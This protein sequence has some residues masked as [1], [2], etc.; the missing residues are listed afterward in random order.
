ML[1][2][3]SQRQIGMALGKLVEGAGQGE[4]KGRLE[5]VGLDALADLVCEAAL[6]QQVG[7]TASVAAPTMSSMDIRKNFLG[8]AAKAN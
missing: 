7:K 6:A 8:E 4:R 2:K 3:E 5:W 1:I